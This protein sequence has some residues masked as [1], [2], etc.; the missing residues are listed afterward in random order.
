MK[1]GLLALPWVLA[2]SV[3]GADADRLVREAEA[4]E[5][6]SDPAR[7]LELLLQAEP[8]RPDD[9]RLLQKIARQYSDLVLDQPTR[10]AKRA[11]AQKALEYSQ[12]ATERNPRD[13]VNVL[14]VA[15]SHGKLAT[16]SDTRDKVR[17]S[18][19][20][21][22]HAEQALALDPG[23]A[24][25]HHILGRWHREVAELSGTA[26]FFVKLFYG[27]LP[28]ASNAE[29]A[30]YLRRATELEPA[31]LNHWLELGHV[32]AAAGDP[33]AARVAWEKGLGLPSRGK[34][35]EPAKQRARVALEALR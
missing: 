6:R 29:A 12:R 13:A 24:W 2:G 28:P 10:D 25:A 32:Q 27:G 18:R 3:F 16:Y 8:A 5:A 20:V 7:A 14:S 22:E 21:R 4:A 9:A 19:L 11:Y 1:A 33:A 23:Y 35:D 31:E 26:R 34:H 17:Y 15:I 30:R